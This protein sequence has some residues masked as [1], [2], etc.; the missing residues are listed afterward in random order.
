MQVLTFELEE[1][2]YSL[3]GIHSTEEDYRLAF[4]LNKYLH[5]KLKRYKDSLDFQNS[6]AEFQ[7][8]LEHA[9]RHNSEFA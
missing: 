6:K 3:V 2:D 4:L 7:T 1:D 5:I 8:A 9:W